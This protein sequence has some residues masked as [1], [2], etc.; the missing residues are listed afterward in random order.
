MSYKVFHECKHH[1]QILLL[2]NSPTLRYT[3]EPVILDF[4]EASNS[5]RVLS[6]QNGEEPKM[7]DKLVAIAT[8]AYRGLG[9]EPVANWPDRGAE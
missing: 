3:S 6:A 7:S 1:L 4:F 8:G 9:L 5:D 2:A